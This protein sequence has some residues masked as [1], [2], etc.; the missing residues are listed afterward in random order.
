MDMTGYVALSRQIALQRHLATIA[1]NIANSSTT[2]YRAEH[3]LFEATL[4][5]AARSARPR[6]AFVQDVGLYRDVAAG[7]IE[8]TGNGLDLAVQG[9][10]Y[11]TFETRAGE[12]YGRGGRLAVDSEGRLVDPQGNPLLDEGG[13]AIVLPAG[14][15]SPTIAEDG[16]VATV[17]GPVARLRLV[18]FANEQALE[19]EGDGLYV[20][21]APPRPA[22]GRIVQGALEGANVAPVLEM[23][24][25]LSTVRAFEGTQRLIETQQDLE[26]RAIE[27]LVSVNG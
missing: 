21:D 5:P 3:T 7:P 16:T 12:R 18:T 13:V 4:E 17:A 10:G 11:F 2:G 14:E 6:V 20:S 8:G 19:R 26:R 1:N 15:R 27:R 22:T 23:T 24:A 9:E 25:M